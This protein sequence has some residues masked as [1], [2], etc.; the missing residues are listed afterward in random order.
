MGDT[1][2]RTSILIVLG[3]GLVVAS[4]LAYQTD[5]LMLLLCLIVIVTCFVVLF[6]MNYRGVTSVL[7]F[8]GVYAIYIILPAIYACYFLASEMHVD[9]VLIMSTIVEG[10]VAFSFGAWLTNLFRGPLAEPELVRFEHQE[11]YD[12]LPYH[13]W[14]SAT[15]VIAVSILVSGRYFLFN[16]PSLR[17]MLLFEHMTESRLAMRA[18]QG[19]YVLSFLYI[20]PTL[21]LLVLLKGNSQERNNITTIALFLVA[22]SFACQA[23]LMLRGNLAIFALMIFMALHIPRMRLSLK[24]AGLGA[25]ALLILIISLSSFRYGGNA[26]LANPWIIF[27][28]I[29]RRFS[30]SIIQLEYVLDTFPRRNLFPGE[31]YLI[32][33]KAL[34]PGA[35]IG[36]N[37]IIYRFMGY[38]EH[39]GTAT[40]TILGE[41]YANF[42]HAGIIIGMFFLGGLLQHM[43]LG[44]I[45]GSK[46]ITEI[47][48]YVF[49][50]IYL[51]KSNI[52]GIGENFFPA[53]AVV[54]PVVIY[55]RISSAVLKLR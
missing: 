53:V 28:K 29:L 40:I 12:D 23:L 25:L 21:S 36:F 54:M 16:L 6:K 44:L 2:S 50:S 52:A 1:S 18:G 11:A 39:G 14:I 13:F 19:Y 49:V 15:I 51:A 7:L 32:D 9:R 10:A 47:F 27:D 34:L 4:L 43:H 37:G 48:G 24:G 38:G 35:D 17:N 8:M 41:F 20:L 33:L 55:L 3:A 26:V 31:S 5:L 42:G 22:Y 30:T 45:R 46:K